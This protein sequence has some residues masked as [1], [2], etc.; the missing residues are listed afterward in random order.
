MYNTGGRVM[1]RYVASCSKKEYISTR[2]LKVLASNGLLDGVK[3]EALKGSSRKVITS[4]KKPLEERHLLCVSGGKLEYVK[5]EPTFNGCSRVTP[6]ENI[7]C[8]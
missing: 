8:I 1:R 5:Y 4:M 2:E 3:L 6:L 7:C